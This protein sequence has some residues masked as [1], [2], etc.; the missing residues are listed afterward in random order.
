MA[1]ISLVSQSLGPVALGALSDDTEGKSAA[2]AQPRRS[3]WDVRLVRDVKRLMNTELANH[4]L[5][6]SL[7]AEKA[8]RLESDIAVAQAAR[9]KRAGP[10]TATDAA[11]VI[12][13]VAPIRARAVTRFAIAPQG[14]RLAYV[15]QLGSKQQW[16]HDAIMAGTD[17]RVQKGIRAARGFLQ[18]AAPVVAG[19]AKQSAARVVSLEA[20]AMQIR[21]ED[22]NGDRVVDYVAIVVETPENLFVLSVHEPEALNPHGLL[23]ETG[24]S[25]IRLGDSPP[26]RVATQ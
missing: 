11:A 7:A 14:A 19:A 23:A 20:G 3:T 25:N 22:R 13:P 24:W 21:A 16:N 12:T 5:W 18:M 1:L 15:D 2:P 10:A 4:P 26:A 6:R 9:A 8:A 17:S